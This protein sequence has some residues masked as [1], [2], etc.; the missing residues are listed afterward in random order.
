M[1]ETGIDFRRQFGGSWWEWE[2]MYCQ[3][4]LCTKYFTLPNQGSLRNTG[5]ICI[6]KFIHSV[7]QKPRR[8]LSFYFRM[9]V[10][11]IYT[12]LA[13]LA[14]LPWGGEGCPGLRAQS[15]EVIGVLA[16]LHS[17][18]SG[19][20]LRSIGSIPFLK[21]A[22]Y[23]RPESKWCGLPGCCYSPLSTEESTVSSCN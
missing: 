4:M 7:W 15:P 9:K 20:A 18:R 10:I 5:R 11:S 23:N 1:T 6:L 21:L 14:A 16:V 17:L 3:G 13:M 2:G 22:T 8:W 12:W 19:L